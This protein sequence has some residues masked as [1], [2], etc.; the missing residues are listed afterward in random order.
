[1]DLA[2]A[3]TTAMAMCPDIDYS[4]PRHILQGELSLAVINIHSIGFGYVKFS[5]PDDI[6]Y[7]CLPV[8]TIKV[9]V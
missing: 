9:V 6:M 3:Y 5:F 2:G 8:K 7:P 4:T 1:M